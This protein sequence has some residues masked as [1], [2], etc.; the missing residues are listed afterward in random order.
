MSQKGEKVASMS[1]S[2]YKNN[3]TNI[4]E[5][6]M[7]HPIICQDERLRQYLQSFRAF[8][9]RP[10][11]EHFETVLMGQLLSEAGHTLSHLHRAVSGKKSLPSLS[12][13]FSD[14]PWDHRF[15]IKHNFSRFWREMQP[16]IDA[17][18]QDRLNEIKKQKI[19]GKRSMPFVTGYLIGDDSTMYKPKG[20]KMQGIGKH[21][22]TTYETQVTGHSLVQ[23]LS[24]IS[25]RSCALEPLLYRQKKDS[26]KGGGPI[27]E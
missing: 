25:G 4:Q 18:R 2:W 12:R 24:T 7:L 16:K 22:S 3:R 17:E 15:V 21:H 20:R 8:F 6:P 5:D 9:S 23:C 14:A 27:Y 26:R 13:F 1:N 10:Q 11:Y 19:R